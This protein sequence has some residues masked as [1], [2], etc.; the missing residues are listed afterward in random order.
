MAA[1]ALDEPLTMHPPMAP[2]EVPELVWGAPCVT[3]GRG[4]VWQA[5]WATGDDPDDGSAGWPLRGRAVPLPPGD[6]ERERALRVGRDH[7]GFDHAHLV[8]VVDV[9]GWRDGLVLVS[10]AAP[11]AATLRQVLERFG[12]LAVGQAVTLGLPL[13]EALTMLHA[14]GLTHGGASID[15]VLVAPD[16]RPLLAG[17]GFAAVMGSP[18]SPVEDVEQFAD[19]LREALDTEGASLLHPV[20]E[21]V[22]AGEPADQVAQVM[23]GVAAPL[24]LVPALAGVAPA[25]RRGRL[26]HR[27]RHVPLVAACSLGAVAGV[28]AVGW[29]SAS[30]APRGAVPPAS[31]TGPAVSAAPQHPATS[32]A[33][34][35]APRPTARPSVAVF[36]PSIAP[37]AP[38]WSA[39]VQGLDS[40][41]SMAFETGR[42]SLLDQVDAP[43]SVALGEDT[44]LLQQMAA[45]RW[46]ARNLRLRVRSLG[47]R[48]REPD[49]VVLVVR[50]TLEPYAFVDSAGNVTQRVAGRGERSHEIV[51]QRR[52]A[53][54]RYQSVRE[55]TN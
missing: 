27:G 4:A 1:A 26:R 52:G 21:A 3:S 45:Q 29:W 24:P 2:P 47:V 54:W 51:L 8:P 19:A 31:P 14:A 22:G 49:R 44:V 38:D 7:V 18:G 35:A 50:D 43:G 5:R 20:W 23:A 32:A 41:R 30:S 25:T 42:A 15:D 28:A 12:P 39:V 33:R 37:Q 53:N 6:R 10:A 36:A 55:V 40:A 48:S 11:A 16:G 46:R 34:P 13:L 9:L 17:V